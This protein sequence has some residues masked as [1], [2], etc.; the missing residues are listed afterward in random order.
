MPTI[1][2]TFQPPDYIKSPGSRTE[3]AQR[4]KWLNSKN[5]IWR[6]CESNNILDLF[7][8]VVEPGRGSAKA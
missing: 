5:N 8:V 2:I 6:R 7:S 1:L 3:I 4:G